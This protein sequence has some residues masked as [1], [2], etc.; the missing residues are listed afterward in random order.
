M[1][2]DYESQPV[3]DKPSVPQPEHR[4]TSGFWRRILAL[5]LD[6]FILGLVG[7][8]S[9]LFLFDFLAE[10]GGRGRLLGFF[11]ALVY[12]GL[13]N[14]TVGKGQTIGKRIMKIQVVNQVGNNISL[15]RSFLRYAILGAPFFLNGALIPPSVLMSPIGHLIG[16]I[17]FGFGGAIIYLYIF[18]R[19]T[20]QT[21]HDLISGTFVVRVTPQ[22]GELP[23]V[24]VWKPHVALVGIW[25]LVV[26]VFLVA[27]PILAQKGPFPELLAVQK[28]IVSSGKVHTATVFVGKSWGTING[29][30]M[31]TTYFRSN[32]IL[33][34]R[35][36]D[37]EAAAKEIA[38]III[39]EYP[40]IMKKDILVVTVAYGYD[41][42]IARA[43]RSYNVQHSPEEW[44][45]NLATSAS[46]G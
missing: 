32:A 43:W 9:G 19:R 46:E 6:G 21:L 7:F 38:T 27:L 4:T 35:P 44:Q 23:P 13:L 18:N 42:G 41:I 11:V 39:R 14:S 17:I 37:Y 12:F 8:V 3:D 33:K 15:S 26:I 10:L 1:E 28:S 20:R 45:G 36:S 40:H 22:Q 5:I 2:T 30:K 29:K 34:R 24:S 16:F 31:E 25:F